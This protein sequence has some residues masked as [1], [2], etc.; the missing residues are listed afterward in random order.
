MTKRKKRPE[1]LGEPILTDRVPWEHADEVAKHLR[2]LPVL[3]NLMKLTNSLLASQYLHVEP[4]LHQLVPSVLTCLVGKTLCEDPAT[5]NHWELRDDAADLVRQVV[6]A[7]GAAYTTLQPRIAKTL[8]GALLDWSKPLTSH[9]GA[10]RGL[11]AMGD[12]AR[13][14]LLFPNL[15]MYVPHLQ[16]ARDDGPALRKSEAEHVFSALLEECAAYAQSALDEHAHW[17]ETE[18]PEPVAGK[19]KRGRDETPV[20]PA[21]SEASPWVKTFHDV[22]GASWE[23]HCKSLK[24]DLSL[25]K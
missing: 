7:Y 6:E 16:A 3:Q 18:Q 20:H 22:F 14:A 13:V 12:G 9:Y 8:V 5:E 21:I 10:V 17:V 1:T 24:L 2:N 15:S 11:G 25:F 23:K 19:G 4:Y